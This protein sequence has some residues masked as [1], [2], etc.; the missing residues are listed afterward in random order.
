M[1]NSTDLAENI[2]FSVNDQL[3][4]ETGK[5]NYIHLRVQQRNGKKRITTIQGLDE[6]F[7][8]KLLLKTFKKDLHCNGSIE[9]N[10]E[11]GK[12]IQLSGDKRKEVYEFFVKENIG[13]KDT[14]KLHGVEDN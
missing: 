8:F 7:N 6:K 5:N 14:I 4:K 2:E 12:V 1:S 3:D 10:K 9:D 13:T 11:F